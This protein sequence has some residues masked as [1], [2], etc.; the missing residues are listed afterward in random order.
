MVGVDHVFAAEDTWAP[1]MVR[2]T[3]GEVNTFAAVDTWAPTIV[4]DICVANIPA[5][6]AT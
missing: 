3:V 1:G 5:V 6:D 4:V 2:V